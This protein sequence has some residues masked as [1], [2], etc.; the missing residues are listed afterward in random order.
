M[1]HDEELHDHENFC[2]GQESQR[3]LDGESCHPFSQR[4]GGHVNLR[5]VRPHESWRKLKLTGQ[6]INVVGL[7]VPE[8]RCCSESSITFDRTDH[9][10]SILKPRRFPLMVDPLVGTP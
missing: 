3:R 7:V 6:E 1:H 2:Q 10:Y 9:Q 8:Y 4:E 5:W